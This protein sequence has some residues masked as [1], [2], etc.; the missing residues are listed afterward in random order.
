M[1][2][3]YN[4][5]NVNTCEKCKEIHDKYGDTDRQIDEPPH[6]IEPVNVTNSKK[7]KTYNDDSSDDE[8]TDYKS[9]GY[10]IKNANEFGDSSR[11]V[12]LKKEY[13]VN[14]D[15]E[16]DFVPEA[17][18]SQMDAFEFYGGKKRRTKRRNR[19]Y[20]TN[21]RTNK[22]KTRRTRKRHHKRKK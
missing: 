20:K 11:R 8:S 9:P 7:R 15:D 6:E 17:P 1:E 3:E 18:A 19:R 5:K 4:E 14:S 22:K 10:S 13:A 12:R 21:K 2:H 16:D